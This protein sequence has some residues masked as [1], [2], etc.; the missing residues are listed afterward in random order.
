MSLVTRIKFFFNKKRFLIQAS[1][2]SGKS[3][4]ISEKSNSYKDFFLYD[5]D[6]V[7]FKYKLDHADRPKW[8]DN[9]DAPVKSILF[10]GKVNPGKGIIT[11]AVLVPIDK[12]IKFA[13]HREA[14]AKRGEVKCSPERLK[15][16]NKDHFIRKRNKFIRHLKRKRILTFSSFEVAVDYFDGLLLGKYKNI[17][18][19]DSKGEL[20]VY[21]CLP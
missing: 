21:E 4:F 15:F 12:F 13:Q 8:L 9:I 6:V 20:I 11:V 18:V 5:S 3:Y 19:I 16:H 7:K 10:C 17:P 1:P 14:R 2:S